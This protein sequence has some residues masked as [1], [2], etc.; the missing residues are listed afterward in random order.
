MKEINQSIFDISNLLKE[1]FKKE[2]EL[3][4]S[5]KNEYKINNNNKNNIG[6]FTP[7]DYNITN[8]IG[9]NII[10]ININHNNSNPFKVSCLDDNNYD[11]ETLVNL[12][13]Q[14]RPEKIDLEINNEQGNYI[15]NIILDFNNINIP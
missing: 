15:I 13:N 7:I 5:L 12:I 14:K 9:N 1:E 4:N 2:K 11:T 10:N 3:K 6:T 8:L